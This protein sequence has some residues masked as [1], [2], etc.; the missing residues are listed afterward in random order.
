MHFCN[1]VFVGP[2]N[3]KSSIELLKNDKFPTSYI[4]TLWDTPFQ[5]IQKQCSNEDINFCLY[6]GK[7][8]ANGVN[9]NPEGVMRTSKAVII[10]VDTNNNTLTDLN[11]YFNDLLSRNEMK[12]NAL[13]IFV[14]TIY[15]KDQTRL[16]TDEEIAKFSKDNNIEETYE[17]TEGEHQKC[18][19][20]LESVFEKT[21][22]TSNTEEKDRAHNPTYAI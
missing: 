21:C 22:L 14:M 20:I 3:P 15:S 4:A 13:P 17:I 2:G 10:S 19:D 16:I 6:A 1:V 9:I 12:G 11:N 8:D 5:T 7:L 18:Q